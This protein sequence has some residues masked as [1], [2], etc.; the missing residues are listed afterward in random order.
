MPSMPRSLPRLKTQ[1]EWAP[2][3]RGLSVSPSVAD[4]M[5]LVDHAAVLHDLLSDEVALTR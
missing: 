2:R 3:L 5:S 1:E 4:L